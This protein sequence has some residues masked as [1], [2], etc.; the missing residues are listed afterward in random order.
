MREDGEKTDGSEMK[1]HT[2]ALVDNAQ[3]TAT[4]FVERSKLEFAKARAQIKCTVTNQTRVV[5][6]EAKEIIHIDKTQREKQVAENEADVTELIR[7]EIFAPDQRRGEKKW[8][9]MR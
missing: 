3:D 5:D 7:E 4:A 1:A 8:D 2:E 6:V 9:E